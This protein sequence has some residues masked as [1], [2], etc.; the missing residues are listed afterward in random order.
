MR[1]VLRVLV[2]AATAGLLSGCA[3]EAKYKA[4]LTSWVDRPEHDL[5]AAWGPPDSAY[6]DGDTKYLTYVRGGTMYMPGVA[7]LTRPPSSGT[8]RTHTPTAAARRWRWQ[9]PAR[10]RSPSATAWSKTGGSRAIT[11][12]RTS[13]YGASGAHPR[14][15]SEIGPRLTPQPFFVGRS[16][17]SRL[18]GLLRSAQAT[19]LARPPSLRTIFVLVAQKFLLHLKGLDDLAQLLRPNIGRMAYPFEPDATRAS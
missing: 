19:R 9:C 8:R 12:S 1:A 7:R 18:Q 16:K 6:T 2:G 17:K 14:S 3:T 4:N 15:G 11:A 13:R 5:I 10:R